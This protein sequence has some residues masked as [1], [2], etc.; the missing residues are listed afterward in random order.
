ML[1]EEPDTAEEKMA[2]YDPE[3]LGASTTPFVSTMAASRESLPLKLEL[4]SRK[5]ASATVM[6]V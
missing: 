1:T 4:G 6:I 5:L 2:G 3:E